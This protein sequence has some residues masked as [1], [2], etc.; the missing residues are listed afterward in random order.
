MKTAP[1]SRIGFR[2]LR[3]AL[4]M[5]RD[6]RGLAA[7][8]FAL[9]VPLMLMMFFGVVEFSSGVAVD[10]KVTLVSRTLS[11]L[12]SQAPSAVPQA[13]YAIVTDN[14]LQNVFSASI[15][16]F[17][18][19]SATPTNATVS[20]IY[21]DVNG[22]ATIQW[23]EAATISSDTATQA[24]LTT[25]VHKPGDV[26]TTSVPPTLLTPHTYL[27]WSEVSYLYTPTVGYQMAAVTLRDVAFTRPRQV[28][29]LIYP[30]NSPLLPPST[31][32][33]CPTAS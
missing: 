21:I 22:K 19:Y 4:D 30:T 16:I 2:M 11:D 23:S 9:I 5:L 10:R 8:E 7:V 27:I 18:P 29:C 3:S 15:S 13:I 12:T 25:S 17:Q 32:P 6:R 20:E 28:V 24:T 26:V 14:Y 31:P 33:S 1:T